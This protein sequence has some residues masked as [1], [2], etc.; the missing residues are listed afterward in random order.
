LRFWCAGYLGS[1]THYGKEER[2]MKGREMSLMRA[3]GFIGLAFSVLLAVQGKPLQAA[4]PIKIGVVLATTGWAGMMGSLE[5][6]AIMV[7][8]DQVNRQ[9]GVLGRPIQVFYE[10]DQSNPTTAA[11]AA[12]KL[13]RDQKVCAVIGSTLTVLAMPIIPIC[14]REQVPNVSLG[15]GHEITMPIKKWI[16]RIPTTDARLSPVMLKFTVNT[17][18]AKKI[19][20]LHSTDASGMMGAKGITD[21]IGKYGASIIITEKFET[22]D[23]N[24][25]PQL[26]KVKR[27]NPDV[28]MLYTSAPPAAVIAKNL[29]QLGMDTTVVASHGVP[30]YDF[31]RM[32]GKIVEPHWIIFSPK[33]TYGETIS[34]DDPWRKNI[35]DPFKKAVNEKFGK[36][37][38]SG[39]Y[40][41]GY[42]GFMMVIEALK[43][44]G[45]DNRAAIRDAME[46]LRFQG[47]LG[48]Y[49]YSA[50]DHDGLPGESIQP[51]VIKDGEFWP[52]KK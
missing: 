10:D 6:D 29:Q 1:K 36:R 50:T 35:Y 34:P 28:I 8:E 22:K 16:F 19:A 51:T 14:E 39:W 32:V 11:V 15:A 31:V 12:T 45:T 2:I 43:A 4:E 9:G 47:L 30:S 40:A 42:D 38:L 27:L 5:K 20:L 49:I 46:R 24:M 13:I 3:I 41:N 23:T 7:A 48:E 33:I 44:A 18:G 52:Y 21:E 26:T 25:I 17:L 37:E